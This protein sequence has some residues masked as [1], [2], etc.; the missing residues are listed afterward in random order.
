[1]EMRSFAEPVIDRRFIGPRHRKLPRGACIGRAKSTVTVQHWAC[2]DGC[3]LP[4][5]A[6][7]AASGVDRHSGDGGIDV[8]RLLTRLIG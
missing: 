7:A 3:R 8:S 1:M 5:W 2:A 6:M 4:T